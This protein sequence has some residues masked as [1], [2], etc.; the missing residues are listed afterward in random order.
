[1]E[2]MTPIYMIAEIGAQETLNGKMVKLIINSDNCLYD[3][4][5]FYEFLFMGSPEGTHFTINEL[6]TNLDYECTLPPNMGIHTF[7]ENSN[8]QTIQFFS[9]GVNQ[10]S[11]QRTF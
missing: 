5:L 10:S 4:T 2:V 6:K 7:V 9:K 11:Y 1:M 8:N 3:K